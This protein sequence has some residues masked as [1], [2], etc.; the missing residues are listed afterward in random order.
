MNYSY[1]LILFSELSHIA[2]TVYP[3]D[4]SMNDS[5]ESFFLVY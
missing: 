4:S 3:T 5:Y 2:Q 1:K